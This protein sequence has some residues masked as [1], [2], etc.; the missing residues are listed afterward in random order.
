[1]NEGYPTVKGH[2]RRVFLKE[3]ICESL[4]INKNVSFELAYMKFGKVVVFFPTNYS[5]LELKESLDRGDGP[6]VS[7]A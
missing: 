2:S 3:D 6:D 1:M 4:D 7:E 5:L